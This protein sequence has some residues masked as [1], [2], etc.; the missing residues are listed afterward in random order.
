MS[1]LRCI[2][3]ASPCGY[4]TDGRVYLGTPIGSGRVYQVTDD[5]GHARVI[6]AGPNCPHMPPPG[7]GF[8]REAH[9]RFGGGWEVLQ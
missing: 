4:F 8:S 9:T 2:K 7:R 5:H 1:A 3:R 6:G